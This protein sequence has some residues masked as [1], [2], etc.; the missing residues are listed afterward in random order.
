M[1]VIDFAMTVIQAWLC[2]DVTVIDLSMVQM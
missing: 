2:C 1:T